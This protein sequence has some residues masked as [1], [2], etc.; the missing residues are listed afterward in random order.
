MNLQNYI[1]DNFVEG[2]NYEEAAQLILRLYCSVDGLPE[3][4][5][6]QCNRNNLAEVFSTLSASG[7]IKRNCILKKPNKISQFFSYAP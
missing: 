1:K 7:F 6:E 4:L 3:T 2:L 5:K